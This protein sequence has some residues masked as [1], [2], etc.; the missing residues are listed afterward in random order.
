MSCDT[1]EPA[2][3]DARQAES[4]E[5]CCRFYILERSAVGYDWQTRDWRDGI[6][7]APEQPEQR[8]ARMARGA[9]RDPTPRAA[10]GQVMRRAR[11]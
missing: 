7:L 1:R 6:Y 5:A 10:G 8:R 3:D 9:G 11:A 2:G 4:A